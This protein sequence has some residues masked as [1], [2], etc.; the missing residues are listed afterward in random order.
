MIYNYLIKKLNENSYLG[1]NRAKW[2][3]YFH[4]ETS[5]ECRARALQLESN[6]D[7]WRWGYLSNTN[8]M[9]TQW[10]DEWL[11]PAPK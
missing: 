2:S 7:A 8:I 11:T 10:R 9:E 6:E 4:P 5:L 1:E 3:C